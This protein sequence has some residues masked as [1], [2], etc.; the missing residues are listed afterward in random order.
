MS[1]TTI[2]DDGDDEQETRDPGNPDGRV[3]HG[4]CRFLLWIGKQD[5]DV[6]IDELG[7]L[8]EE[9]RRREQLDIEQV[10]LSR[11]SA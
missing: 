3:T 7:D 5:R 6:E 1:A 10:D 9:W 2:S 4:R 8:Y 11:W